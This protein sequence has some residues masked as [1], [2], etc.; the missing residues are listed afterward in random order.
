[1]MTKT[2]KDPL[3]LNYRIELDLTEWYEKGE[4]TAAKDL[5]GV[6]ASKSG[7]PSFSVK[8]IP[9][10]FTGKRDAK[11]VV[12]MLNPGKD[13]KSADDSRT[14]KSEIDKLQIDT[15]NGKNSFIS[16]YI[17]GKSNFGKLSNGGPFDV[18][19]ARFLKPWEESG[20]YFPDNFPQDYKTYKE[21]KR[22][23]LLDKLQLELVPYCSKEFVT[24][25][26]YLKLLLPFLETLFHEI[27]SKSRTYVIFCGNDFEKLFDM[28]NEVHPKCIELEV[29]KAKPIIVPSRK[30]DAHCKVF[31]IY[32]HKVLVANT[33]AYRYLNGNSMS[34]YGK[35]CFDVY[36]SQ[37]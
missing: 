4:I 6:I 1:M 14:I 27:F 7:E 13:V 24:N 22:V 17:N 29:E 30:I 20:I 36:N 15:T 31:K 10:H 11:T 3:T 33:F 28:Y 35:F 37:P 19:Q 2:W 8:G 18:K 16:S 12:V 26:K 32:N 5:D 25:P 23:V 9:G 21:A 34:E